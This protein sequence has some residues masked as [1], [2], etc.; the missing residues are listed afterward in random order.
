MNTHCKAVKFTGQLQ[1]FYH[2]ISTLLISC[3][4]LGS[5]YELGTCNN[6]ATVP[7]ETFP[8]VFSNLKTDQGLN[9][10]ADRSTRGPTCFLSSSEGLDTQF[11][12]PPDQKTQKYS[13]EPGSKVGPTLCATVADEDQAG[14]P[15][16]HFQLLRFTDAVMTAREN[17]ENLSLL[18]SG[19]Y[20]G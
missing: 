14:E 4:K 6:F 16:S 20:N 5:P 2:S 12:F 15:L 8:P 7:K 19:F 10:Y 11:G 3:E 1:C 18:K 13:V 9:N 17:Q